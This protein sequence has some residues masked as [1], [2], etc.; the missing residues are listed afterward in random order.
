MFVQEM[1]T[2]LKGV[3]DMSEYN[4][5]NGIVDLRVDDR[6]IHGIVA[7]EWLPGAKTTRVMVVNEDASKSD[8]LRSTLKMATPGGIALSVLA[9]SKAIENFG[10]NK[11]VAQ[12]VFVIGREIADVYALYKGGVAFK[13]VNLGNVTQNSGDDILVL[14]K[15]VRVTS[16]ERQMLKEMMLDGIKITCQ[17]RVG[18]NTKDCADML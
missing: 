18:D 15:T 6:M 7:A 11:Y 13:R 5:D 14:D 10:S 4:S 8:M 2:H 12:R 17:F 9:P 3:N 1:C 16:A